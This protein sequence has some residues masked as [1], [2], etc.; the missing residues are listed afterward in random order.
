[1]IFVAKDVSDRRSIV[2]KCLQLVIQILLRKINVIEL[3]FV[4]ISFNSTLIC[5]IVYNSQDIE[6]T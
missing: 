4:S 3:R 2:Q 6:E 5:I 1:M